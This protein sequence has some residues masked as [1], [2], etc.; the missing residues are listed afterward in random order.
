M[1][2]ILFIIALLT[3][4]LPQLCAYAQKPKGIRAGV[5]AGVN[6]SHM[7]ENS[8][9]NRVGAHVGV[10]GE[11][12]LPSIARGAYLEFG[13]QFTMKGGKSEI[14]IQEN[15]QRYIPEATG[16]FRLYY[17][18]IPVRA[19]YRFNLTKKLNLLVTAGPYVSLGVAGKQD[20]TYTRYD[21]PFMSEDTYVTINQLL[22]DYYLYDDVDPFK[23][24]ST[25]TRVDLGVGARVGLE[26]GGHFQILG[27][28]DHGLISINR[29]SEVRSRN[30]TVSLAYMF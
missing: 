24:S 17:L 26:I 3:A 27:G 7:G 1:K 10:K 12:G 25:G 13:L 9:E 4:A 6:I 2:R 21:N 30:Y 18:E 8:L 20:V 5:T 28:Y 16:G 19:G 23:N 15:H 11:A 29:Y 22:Q 14:N